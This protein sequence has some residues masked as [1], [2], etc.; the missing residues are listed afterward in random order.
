MFQTPIQLNE[1][2]PLS[3]FYIL[4]KKNLEILYTVRAFVMENNFSVTTV[5]TASN[6][7]LFLEVLE[8]FVLPETAVQSYSKKQT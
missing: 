6:Q 7:N 1:T 3:H 5:T 4:F 2:P 8:P